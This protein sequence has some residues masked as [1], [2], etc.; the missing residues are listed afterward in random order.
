MISVTALSAGQS[1]TYFG[2]AA[3]NCSP[4]PVVLVILGRGTCTCVANKGH[5]ST[6]RVAHKMFSDAIHV[7]GVGM[8]ADGPQYGQATVG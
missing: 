3:E 6:S 2:C 7:K 5:T 4:E 8:A 1:Y